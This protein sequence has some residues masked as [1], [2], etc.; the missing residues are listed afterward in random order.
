MIKRIFD[1]IFSII[2]TFIILPILIVIL[3]LNLI[4]LGRPILFKQKRLGKSNIPFFIY[5]FRTMH[6]TKDENEKLLDDSLRQSEYGNILRKYSLD[7]LPSFYNVFKGD[8]SVVG[9]RPLL[10]EYLNLYSKEQIK[11]HDV[12]PGITGWAQ[13]NGRNSIDWE[14]KFILDVWYV[15][16]HNFFLDLKII[17]FTIFKVLKREGIN[18]KKNQDKFKGKR[19]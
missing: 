6:N 19:D 16:N 9:P 8:M 12:K 2:V 3:F 4:V 1:I 7:E 10:I 14:K 18:H 5:K 11:R 17:F 13:I 15:K